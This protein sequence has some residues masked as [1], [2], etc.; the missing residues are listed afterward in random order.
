M[1]DPAQMASGNEYQPNRAKTN[2][3]L[4]VKIDILITELSAYFLQK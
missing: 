1:K 4:K 3:L 2:V